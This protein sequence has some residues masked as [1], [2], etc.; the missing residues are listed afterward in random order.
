MLLEVLSACES[1]VAALLR[2][3]QSKSADVKHEE[4][5]SDNATTTELPQPSTP[6]DGGGGGSVPP[7]SS[8]DRV[9][10]KEEGDGS[11]PT[12]GGGKRRP[13][14]WERILNSIH[15]QNPPLKTI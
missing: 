8:G 3:H 10:A 6:S 14:R 2:Q 15:A 13:S 7:R 1:K 5:Q 9:K 4:R 11:G 12:T